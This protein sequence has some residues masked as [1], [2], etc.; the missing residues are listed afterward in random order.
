[1]RKTQKKKRTKKGGEREINLNALHRMIDKAFKEAFE[2]VGIPD[3]EYYDEQLSQ[4]KDFLFK[5]ERI[6][7]IQKY[8]KIY[9]Y[10]FPH[11]KNTLSDVLKDLAIRFISGKSM[12]IKYGANVGR[13]RFVPRSRTTRSRTTRSRTIRNNTTPRNSPGNSPL[14]I[15]VSQSANQPN[16]HP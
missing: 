15:S 4:F 9:I 13:T 10:V 12:I 11:E 5:N 3:D 14:P 16:P 7:E 6:S 2:Y 1:M 8:F